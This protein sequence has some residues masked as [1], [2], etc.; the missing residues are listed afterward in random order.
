[1]TRPRLHRIVA[2]A[3]L[4]ALAPALSPALAGAQV[5]YPPETSPFR[6]LVYR[7]EVSVVSGYLI[8]QR[9]PAGVAYQGGPLIGVRYAAQFGNP[10][11]VG[12]QALTSRAGRSVIDPALRAS[13]RGVG[14]RRSFLTMVEAQLGVALTGFRSWHGLVPEVSGGIGLVTDW[15]REDLGGYRFGTPFA[16]NAGSG[17]RW[18]PGGR[19][20]VRLDVTDHVFR[21]AY[22]QSFYT[23]TT[24]DPPVLNAQ[25]ATSLWTHNAS[26]KIGL[27]YLFDR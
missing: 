22:P 7:Q 9:D 20:Q 11:F 21:I 24:S 12:V 27:S 5:G 10:L 26:V 2:V 23:S 1:M 19:L 25:Q 16:I 15:K 4:A 8:Q 6:D 17:V 14:T 18:Q 3:L 13:Q